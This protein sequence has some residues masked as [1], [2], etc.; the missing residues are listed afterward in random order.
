MP[1][2]SAQTPSTAQKSCFLRKYSGSWNRSA[3]MMA[4]AE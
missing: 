3:A 4:L 2:Q 1:V